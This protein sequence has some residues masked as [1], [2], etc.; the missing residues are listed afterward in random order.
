MPRRRKL[1]CRNLMQAIL[2]TD[3]EREFV[4]REVAEIGEIDD[5]NNE[6]AWRAENTQAVNCQVVIDG[7]TY[8]ITVEDITYIED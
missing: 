4:D 3:F 1:T 2:N 6:N 5:D 7:R 8:L